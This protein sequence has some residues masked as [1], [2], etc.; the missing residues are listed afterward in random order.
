MAS[1]LSSQIDLVLQVALCPWSVARD[2]WKVVPKIGWSWL[3]IGRSKLHSLPLKPR[4]CDLSHSLS[5]S[6]NTVESHRLPPLIYWWAEKM[7]GKRLG[8]SYRGCWQK[9]ERTEIT[10]IPNLDCHYNCANVKQAICR[11]CDRTGKLKTEK[12][13]GQADQER[14]KVHILEV[15]ISRLKVRIQDLQNHK[16]Q[17]T[18]TA[19]RPHQPYVVAYNSSDSTIQDQ[20]RPIAENLYVLFHHRTMI[21]DCLLN[22]FLPFALVFPQHTAFP[23]IGAPTFSTRPSVTR[24]LQLLSSLHIYL[25]LSRMIHS[26]KLFISHAPLKRLLQHYPEVIPIKLSIL[27]RMRYF[28]PPISFRMGGSFRGNI[29]QKKEGKEAITALKKS[30]SVVWQPW[31]SRGERQ[32]LGL[33]GNITLVLIKGRDGLYDEWRRGHWQ[34]SI[35]HKGILTMLRVGGLNWRHIWR[36]GIRISPRISLADPIQYW[37]VCTSDSLLFSET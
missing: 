1:S 28:L 22:G 2:L 21:V 20:P 11:Q 26:W 25:R 5:T 36:N 3:P 14:S 24:P 27:S 13:A 31:K 15:N 29:T 16:H 12:T 19:M 33:K 30:V 35:G 9:E 6:M 37:S 4:S 17:P 23:S 32:V 7:I 34:K 8:L 18:I 10:V